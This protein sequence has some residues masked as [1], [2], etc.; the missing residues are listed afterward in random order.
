[1][2]TCWIVLCIIEKINIFFVKEIS[3]LF[4]KSFQLEHVTCTLS[5]N[6]FCLINEW[7]KTMRVSN[8]I[9]SPQLEITWSLTGF[10]IFYLNFLWLN[11]SFL[12][13]IGSLGHHHHRGRRLFNWRCHGL[14][15]YPLWCHYREEDPISSKCR[16]SGYGE[17]WIQRY[18][19]LKFS[20]KEYIWT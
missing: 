11:V 17:L 13:R 9:L 4:S 7:K 6:I 19:T 5:K 18:N 1:M 12:Y 3:L 16:S 2:L 14:W 20:R 15:Q 10:F 8:P